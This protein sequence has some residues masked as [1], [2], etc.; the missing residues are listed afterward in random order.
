MKEN[1]RSWKWRDELAGTSAAAA[2]VKLKDRIANLVETHV[3]KRRP[4]NK[5][6]PP[7]LSQDILREIRRRKRMWTRDKEKANKDEYK[8]QDK[9]TRNMIR[10]AKKKFERRL[11]DGGGQNKRPFYAYVKNRTKTRQSVGPLKDEA[12]NTVSDSGKMADLLN[13]TF[14]MA[15]T[16]EDRNVIPEPEEQHEGEELGQIFVTVRDVKQKIKK[17][18]REAASGPDGIGPAI[19]MEMNNEL[20][21]VLACI[22]NKSLRTGEVPDDWREANV[23]P[24]FKKGKRTAPE[25]YR[26]VSLTSVCCKLLESVIKDKVM[27]HLKKHKLIRNSQHGFL[28]GR[29]CTTNLL[30]F[31]E[32]VTSQVDSGGAF[33]A[34]FLDFAKAFDKVPTAR[35]LKKVK[36]HGITG[37]L[38]NW[39]KNWLTDRRQRVVLDGV[40]SEWIAVLSGVP[41]GS[42]LGPLL[43]LLFINDLDL[44]ASEVTAMAKFADDTKVGQQ[45]VTAADREA[46]QSA[47]D[48]LCNWARV[49]GMQFNVAKCKVMHFGRNNPGY[50]YEM[51]GQLLEEVENERDI[52]VTVSNTLKPASQCTRA[53]GT[54][55]TVLGQI[56][57]AFHYRD[58][59]VFVKL[60]TTYVRPH[61]EFCT[62]AWSPWTRADIDCLESVQKKM[63]NMVSGLSAASYEDKLAELGLES[64][65]TR[66]KNTDIYTMHKLVHG[67]GDVDTESW[68]E[69]NVGGTVTR[70]RSDP[71]NVLSKNGTLELRRNFFTLRVV[72]DWNAV[73]FDIKNIP[74]PGKFKQALRRWQ[75]GAR[76][77][78]QHDPPAR[79]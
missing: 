39:I 47:L 44:A 71:L 43:F 17:L 27:V 10:A 25:N 36:A 42:V 50:T 22:F 73:P 62:P 23:T 49:W 14:G 31:F 29:N 30:S 63:V 76:A 69:K 13:K 68:F 12:G 32:K 54:A 58:R 9:K 41:Q 56:S 46:L 45:I 52:G 37:Q 21:P 72:K 20:A 53:A 70:A 66:R 4:R 33:D 7:W 65:E 26:P 38:L 61:L 51:A 77:D 8:A 67:I 34:I 1:V 3:P 55:R 19:L 5:N 15:F 60:Y 6:R 18:R 28:P 48:K 64:L 78:L 24:I 75:D 35:L 57:R 16:R 11:A 59:S 40:C 2:W 74:I 79:R